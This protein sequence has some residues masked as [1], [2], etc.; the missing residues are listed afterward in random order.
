MVAMETKQVFVQLRDRSLE[1]C[2]V[3]IAGTPPW[4]ITFSG[5]SFDIKEFQAEDLF[6]ACCLLR[7]HLEQSGCS[8]LC[9]AS[10]KDIVVS[11]MSRQM[12][13]GRKAYVVSLG[14]PASK[15]DMVDIFDHAAADVV[16]T[17]SEQKKFYTEWVLSLG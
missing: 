5:P 6:R 12:G 11:G 8:L 16:S 15:E 17:I 3:D 13:G 7:E 10:R 2:N 4:K 14:Q 9:N 1:T